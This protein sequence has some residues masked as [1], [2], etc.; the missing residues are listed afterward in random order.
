MKIIDPYRFGGGTEFTDDKSLYTVI[1]EYLN[2][3]T[4]IGSLID[5]DVPW[6][7]IVEEW[8]ISGGGG[9]ICGNLSG[10]AY[11][12]IDT[13]TV[14]QVRVFFRDSANRRLYCYSTEKITVGDWGTIAITHSGNSLVSGIS[15][16]INGVAATINTLTD[17]IVGTGT[18]SSTFQIL[19]RG[20]NN[21]TRFAKTHR[22]RIWD[23][24]LTSGEVADPASAVAPI[25][26][27]RMGNNPSDD[28]TGTTG[29]IY[30][31]VGGYNAT[32]IGTIAGDII[33]EAPSTPL[34]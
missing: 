29:T 31:E 3:G 32:P 9:A 12:Y 6:T 22:F 33:T 17:T 28:A 21:L 25:A 13:S 2:C 27:W 30:D 23:A 7:I 20:D 1:N 8:M 24:E 16:Y 26:D 19:S 34:S 10:T 5:H 15:I 18:N 4:T 11:W 14:E